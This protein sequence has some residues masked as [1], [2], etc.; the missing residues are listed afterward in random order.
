MKYKITLLFLGLTLLIGCNDDFMDL[1]P[2]DELT[3][4]STFAN[5]ENIQN[6][7]WQL[8]ETFPAYGR[9]ETIPNSWSLYLEL[10]NLRQSDFGAS[11]KGNEESEWAWLKI[12][13][14]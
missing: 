13:A 8:Y 12:P 14:T 10:S 11:S 5:Y 4:V 9:P 1:E 7:A 2:K 6:F 3:I